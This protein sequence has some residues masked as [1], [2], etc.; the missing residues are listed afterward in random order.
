M[1]KS[2]FKENKLKLESAVHELRKALVFVHQ[3][4]TLSDVHKARIK[5]LEHIISSLS[6]EIRYLN[7]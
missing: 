2:G 3:T 6:E 1:Q 4:A 5:S 7:K